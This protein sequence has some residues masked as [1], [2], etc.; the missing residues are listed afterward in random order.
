[1][2]TR[3]TKATMVRSGGFTQGKRTTCTCCVEGGKQGLRR[4]RGIS[5]FQGKARPDSFRRNHV[6]V[7]L[8]SFQN[9]LL[10][11]DMRKSW[12]EKYNGN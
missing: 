9:A 3:A 11:K 12:Q 4:E 1:M 8:A 5:S 6:T 10:P 2:G 7:A